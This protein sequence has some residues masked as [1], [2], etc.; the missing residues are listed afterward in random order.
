M[1]TKAKYLMVGTFTLLA[2]LL[3]AGFLIFSN[4]KDTQTS[5]YAVYFKDGVRGL[6]AG[7]SVLFN[8]VP[9]GMVKE[10]SLAQGNQSQVRVVL[11]ISSAVI[12]RE[13]C[14]AFLEIQGIT[15][16]SSVYISGGSSDSPPLDM[17]AGKGNDALPVI[18]ETKSTLSSLAAD[19]PA[20]INNATHLITS[21]NKA[22]SDENMENLRL[23]MGAMAQISTS[24]AEEGKTLHETLTRLKSAS[25][26]LNQ[27]LTDADQVLADDVRKT[28]VSVQR[29]FD[30]LNNLITGLEPELTRISG[31]GAGSLNQLLHDTRTLV[32]DLDM[33]VRDL[34]AN[35]QRFIFGSDVPEYEPR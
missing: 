32:R 15:G 12:I 14:K 24:L 10:I 30:N 7:N 17:K 34:N 28:I 19:I 33:L 21:M 31:H 22:F 8:G 16:M 23:T 27:L 4:A 25:E 20:L 6:S 11:E 26:H 3:F 29:S 18:P 2:A 35:P 1:E 5:Q 13:D 9:V